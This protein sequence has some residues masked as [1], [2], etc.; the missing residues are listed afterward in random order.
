MA[1]YTSFSIPFDSG[2]ARAVRVPPDADPAAVL[3]ALDLPLYRAIVV[4]HGGAGG[5]APD[6]IEAVTRFFAASLTPFAEQ[7]RVLIADGGTQAGTMAAMGAARRAVGGTFPLVGVAPLDAVRYPGSASP[8]RDRAPLDA[9]HSHFVLAEGDTFGV[10]SALLVGLLRGAEV[11]GAALIVNGGAIVREE[12]L[13]HAALGNPVIA[14]AGSGRA[15]DELSD[16]RSELRARMAPS[17]VE[18]VPMADPPGLTAALE[19]LLLRTPQ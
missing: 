8:A 13:S 2:P 1:V 19:R 4:L 5:M 14:V 7:R 18:V 12:T 6:L 17:A 15:A 16:P 10:E 3:G 11:P 9:G